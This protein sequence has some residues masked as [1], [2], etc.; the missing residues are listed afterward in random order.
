MNNKNPKVAVFPARIV[1]L[2]EKKSRQK[3]KKTA[4]DMKIQN[5]N[6]KTEKKKCTRQSHDY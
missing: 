2:S 4:G 6:Q 1:P 3:Q 5:K